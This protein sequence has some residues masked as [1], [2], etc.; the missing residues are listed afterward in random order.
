VC[1]DLLYC[2][3]IFSSNQIRYHYS[4]SGSDSSDS[5]ATVLES[6]T[7]R[8]IMSLSDLHERIGEVK[9]RR[10]ARHLAALGWSSKMGNVK[11]V[12]LWTLGEWKDVVLK[13]NGTDVAK[14]VD[15]LEATFSLTIAMALS[16]DVLEHFFQDMTE[17]MD[18]AFEELTSMRLHSMVGPKLRR[19][20]KRYVALKVHLNMVLIHW[21]S[22][23]IST[24]QPLWYDTY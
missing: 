5:D 1:F 15:K 16:P 20:G 10:Y 11:Q 9:Y 24:Q 2:E 18:V 6:P 23:L 4:G 13:G 17:T 19:I 22:A 21:K 14:V 8:N 3:I 7:S 12:T